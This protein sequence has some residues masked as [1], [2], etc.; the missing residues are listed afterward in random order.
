MSPEQVRGEE[1]D[2]RTD[3]FSLGV[4]LYEMATGRP[5]FAGDTSGVVFD[6]I[7][8]RAPTA[9]VRLNPELPAELERI[10]DKALEKDR[11]LRYQSARD[12]EADLERLRRDA[13]ASRAVS[14][15]VDAAGA[16]PARSRGRLWA[17][18]GAAAALL[19][20]TG[21]WLG[22]QAGGPE[23]IAARGAAQPTIA[24]LPFRNLGATESIDYLRLAVPDEIT[25]ALSRTPALAVRPFTTR[26]DYEMSSDL[27]AAGLELRA[28]NLV[29]G[30]FFQEGDRLHLTLEAVDVEQDRVLWRQSFEVASADLIS[31]RQ[32]VA[33]GVRSGLL[34][35]LGVGSRS[36][37]GGT[38]PTNQEAYDAYLRSLAISRD[39][40]PNKTAIAVLEKA[41]ALDPSYAPAWSELS[42]RYGYDGAYSDGGKAAYE[43][44]E[45]AARRSME[46]DPDLAAGAARIPILRADQGELTAGYDAAQ[47]LVERRPDSA[48]AHFARSYVLRYGGLLEEAGADCEIAHAL[49]PNNHHLR[50]C[51]HVMAFLGRFDRALDFYRLDADSEFIADAVGHFELI[52]GRPAASLESWSRLPE[53]FRFYRSEGLILKACLE[54][55]PDLAD[56]AAAAEAEASAQPDPEI[57]Y[58]GAGIFAFCGQR[59]AALRLLRQAVERNYCSFPNV[60]RDRQWDALREDPGFLE[61]RDQA[62]ACR[63]R[64]REHVRSHRG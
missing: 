27:R 15:A 13:A 63:D 58:H 24:V 55:S 22:R 32:R 25:T 5:P 2:E 54:G 3:L 34:P 59:D 38:R 28:A 10:L 23:G 20:A 45:A 50:T 53:D 64:F 16:R 11:S 43:R 46:L 60:D 9:P 21:L 42:L 39:E 57:K 49:D 1:L 62:I 33:G 48:E 40:E 17:G 19:L 41:V 14:A 36:L 35:L 44:S 18:L 4:V 37:S 7:L 31:L 47:A 61:V 26:A 12:L 52:R 30:Q 6:Q 8:N 56:L 29:T 51:G